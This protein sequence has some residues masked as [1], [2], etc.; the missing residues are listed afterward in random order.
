MKQA[1][2]P[3][4]TTVGRSLVKINMH[5]QKV[6]GGGE[7]NIGLFVGQTKYCGRNSPHMQYNHGK[8]N[9]GE[10]TPQVGQP[11]DARLLVTVEYGQLQSLV[12]RRW[13]L[14]FFKLFVCFLILKLQKLI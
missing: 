6:R 11:H 12:C 9:W 4:Q 3:P 7:R 10:S 14:F 1:E 2:K 8:C 5:S 13:L